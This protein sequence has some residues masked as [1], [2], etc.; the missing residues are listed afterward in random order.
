MPSYTDSPSI[1]KQAVFRPKMT[2]DVTMEDIIAAQS[3]FF[4]ELE[5]RNLNF[6]SVEEDDKFYESLRLFLEESFNW[7]D[8]NSYN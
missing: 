2:R 8:Y 1:T 4:A 7:P 5:K 3:A 6:E